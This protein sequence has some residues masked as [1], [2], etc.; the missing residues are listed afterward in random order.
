MLSW[1]SRNRTPH[2]R[3]R[4]RRWKSNK[5]ALRSGAENPRRASVAG[6]LLRAEVH[7]SCWMARAFRGAVGMRGCLG[8]FFKPAGDIFMHDIG[9][10]RLIRNAFLWRVTV[11]TRGV[12]YSS[13][14][15]TS[16]L[17]KM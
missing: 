15:Q 8:F 11:I 12:G 5:T 14:D 13:M 2:R 3:C 9:A 1:S 17:T 16:I 6:F 4:R 7:I 10:Q